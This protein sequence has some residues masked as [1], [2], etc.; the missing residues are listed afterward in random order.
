MLNRIVKFFT[1]LK[2]TVVCLCLGMLLIF[3][4]TL[5]QVDEGLYNAQARYFKSWFIWA[6]TLLGHKLPIVLP[7]GYLL[8]GVLLVNLL[9]AHAQRFTLSKKK[10]GIFMVHAGLI[11]LLLGQLLTDVLSTESAMRI[12]EGEPV[13]YSRDFHSNEL[14]VIDTSPAAADEVVAI[15]ESF[16]A[17]QTEIRHEKL[18]VILRI[19]NYWVNADL[20]KG[21]A[22]GSVATTVNQGVGQGVYVLPKPPVVTMDERNLPAAVVEVVSP[23]GG[24]LGTWLLSS[25]FGAKQTFTQ[26][27]KTYQLALRFTRYY[28]PYTITLQK[29]T[30]ELYKGTDIPKNYA[31]QLRLQR[32]DTGEDREVLIYMNNPLRYAGETYYQGSFEKGDKVSILQ[33]VRNPGWLTPYFACLLMSLG[34]I[35]QFMSHLIGFAMKRRTA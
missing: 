22:N 27:G 34:L 9:S 11:L 3:I 33:V 8:G 4:G 14:A 30:H 13:N 15:P 5:A 6:P 1:S 25:Q 18:P 17:R 7:G 2:L 35:V 26:A 24:S 31:S 12:P 29:F 28:K 32:A 16:V 23:Q 10:I 19:K 21:K 20:L